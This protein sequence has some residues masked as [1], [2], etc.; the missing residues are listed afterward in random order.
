MARALQFTFGIILLL[1]LEVYRVYYIMPFPGSQESDTLDL[2]YFLHENIF[3]L[4][5]IGIALI[6]FPAWYYYSL[7]K[8]KAKILVSLS[9]IA[10]LV[11]AYLVNYK[12]AADTMFY[13]PEH[14]VFAAMTE[15]KIGRNDLVIGVQINGESKAYPIQLIGY[16]HQVRD[17]IGGQ[18]VMVTYCTVCR[19]G[20]VFSPAVDGKIET[21]RLVGMDHF[22]A[23]FE[24]ASTGSWWRQATG[25]AVAGVQKGKVL[26]EIA[27]EQM[28]LGAWFERYPNTTVMQPDSTFT[29][30]YA[31]LINYGRGK[32]KG[33]LTRR[34]SLSWKEKS[35]VVGVVV[36]G[37]AR[38]YDWNA[39]TEQR[40]INDTLGGL[41]ILVTVANDSGSFH[42]WNRDSLHFAIDPSSKQLTDAE[43]QSKW[44]WSGQ[45]FSGPL[46]G[47]ALPAVQSYQEFWHSWRTFHPSTTKH[48]SPN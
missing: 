21:F 2:A 35:W 16:H 19:T 32:S 14:K 30:G 22:N 1:A 36:K 42:V 24:D 11:V 34:D 29:E 5:T 45:C 38:A 39:L 43:T 10:V 28:T 6:L 44:S 4:R 25:E 18:P 46:Q 20:R 15:N 40:V 41:P 17:S 3:Y 48:N 47:N 37:H 23:M 27:A 7:G 9:I 31:T 26:K 8:L 12:F 33:H 13:Q